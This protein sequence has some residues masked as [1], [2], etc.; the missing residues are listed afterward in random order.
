MTTTRPQEVAQQAYLARW[1]RFGKL[2]LSLAGSQVIWSLELAYG[3]PYLLSIGLSKQATGLVWIAAPL[4]GL[5][6]QPVL[7][8]LSDS[9]TSRY[10]RRK[11]MALSTLLVALATCLI[12]YSEPLSVLVLHLAGLGLGDWDPVRHRRVQMLTHIFSV[13]G[14]WVLD[15]NIN[16]LQVIARALILDNADT[17]EQNEAHAWQGRMLHA[18]NILGYWCGWVDLA[19]WPALAWLGGGQ[20]RRLAM[21]SIVCLVVC[22]T[23]TCATTQEAPNKRTASPDETV[24]SRI[25]ASLRQIWQIGKALPLSIRRVC[26]AQVFTAMAWFPFM[27][28]S[29]TYVV[30]MG[31]RDHPDDTMEDGE[32]RGSFA[33][34]L[35]AVLAMA[36]GLLLPTLSLAGQVSTTPR[37]SS[38]PT[39]PPMPEPAPAEPVHYRGVALRTMW[40]W[41]S[42]FH[43]ALLLGTLVVSTQAQAVWLIV[44]MGIPWS[45]WMWVP[46]ALIGEFVRELEQQGWLLPDADEQRSVQR[47]MDGH[48]SGASDDSLDDTLSSATQRMSS[49]ASAVPFV[50]RGREVVQGGDGVTEESECGGTILG[51]HNIAVVV[52][53]FV[54]SV[55]TSLIFRFTAHGGNDVAWV[56]RLGGVMA[57]VAALLARAIPMTLSERL[58]DPDGYLR[59]PDQD[60]GEEA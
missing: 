13:L 33:L 35:F 47:L 41:G 40:M 4:S 23:V 55:L 2:T 27:F 52:P 36:S 19:A 8:A 25:A 54:A 60:E 34:L 16:G 51:I 58:A 12:A 17:A 50:S 21:V 18:G 32:K 57:L 42:L 5:I 9:S 53:Q 48:R 15:F 22:V 37:A 14:F 11:Y 24:Y 44:L 30:D 7:G 1:L 3:T 6:M 49:G 43:A 29:T 26:L 31:R 10:R 59:L 39:T 46:F 38:A 20:F 56:L 45:L 28:Y